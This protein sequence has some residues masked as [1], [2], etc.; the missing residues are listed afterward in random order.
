MIQSERRRLGNQCV[1]KGGELVLYHRL[2]GCH[3]QALTDLVE[4]L[5]L[6]VGQPG[7]S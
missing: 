5:G 2:G 1:S 6:A 7:G 4:D 3:P